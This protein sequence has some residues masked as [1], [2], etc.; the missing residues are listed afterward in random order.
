MFIDLVVFLVTGVCFYTDFTRRKLYNL[1]LFPA[2]FLGAGYHTCTNGINGCCFSLQ[3]LAAGLA[4]LLIPYC[5]GG[6][7]AGDVK[8]LGAVGALKGP[9]FIFYAFLAGAIAGGLL[10]LLYL[11]KNKSMTRVLI[12]IIRPFAKTGIYRRFIYQYHEADDKNVAIPYGAA[13]AVGIIT[14]YLVR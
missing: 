12:K 4:L 13:I 9:V 10:S 2:V 11:L 14:A 5:A 3:G 6:V 8:F 1:V 7:G